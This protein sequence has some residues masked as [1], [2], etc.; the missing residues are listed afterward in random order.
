MSQKLKTYF[1]WS[2]GKDSALALYHLQK[3]K[4]YHI[5]RLVTCVNH[6]HNRVSMHGLRR[7]L[8][9][10]QSQSIGLPMTTVELPEQA[11]MA[12]YN[13]I[14]NRAIGS[15]K[16]KG[17]SNCG[18]GDIFL[19]DLR[20]HRYSQ[21]KSHG[22]TSQFPLWKKDTRALM[23]DFIKLGFK[24]IVICI[25]AQVLDKSFLGQ[26][27][28]A[29][30]LDSLPAGVDT[31]GENG[32]FHTFCYAGPIFKK[33]I[34]FE[35]GELVYKSYKSPKIDAGSDDTCAFWFCDLLPIVKSK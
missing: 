20:A 13:R 12:S 33:P 21:L 6:H 26:E 25:D 11:S 31:C 35:L 34:L 14:M 8:L 9:M 7:E 32:E 17:Y 27:I 2:S 23:N 24:A 15:L 30:F 18:F 28:D 5:D 1:N 29:N 19:E 16:S 10:L 4:Q 22:I 3:Y